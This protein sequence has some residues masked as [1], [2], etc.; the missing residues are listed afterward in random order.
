MKSRKTNFKAIDLTRHVIKME[1]YESVCDKREGDKTDLFCYDGAQRS[2]MLIEALPS[3]E[4]PVARSDK[5]TELTFD[6]GHAIALTIFSCQFI[7]GRFSDLMKVMAYFFSVQE[8]GASLTKLIDKLGDFLL[9]RE[10]YEHAIQLYSEAL[11]LCPNVPSYHYR[12]SYCYAHLAKVQEAVKEARMTVALSP[13]NYQ[14]LSALGWSL[15][16]AEEFEEAKLVLD[17][18]VA[19]ALMNEGSDN[20]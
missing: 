3:V 13:N 14:Y 16:D 1:E 5:G 19:L 12:L 17:K 15:V 20:C 18:A 9:C 6:P 7:L 10:D 8:N 11:K 4:E 2:F